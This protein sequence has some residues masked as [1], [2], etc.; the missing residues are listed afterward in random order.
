[1]SEINANP[2]K[3][4]KP[5]GGTLKKSIKPFE[6]TLYVIGFVIGSGIFLKPSSVLKNT[7]STAGSLMAWIVGGVIAITAALTIGEIAAYIPKTGGMHTYLT[8]LYGDKFGF[9]YGWTESVIACTG[10]SAALAI[11]FATFATFFLPMND[12][13]LK[14]FAILMIVLIAAAQIISTRFGVWLQTVSTIGKLVP[15]I[16]LVAFG[17]IHGTVNNLS[18]ASA[19]LVK[20]SGFGTALLGVLWAYDGWLAVCTLGGEI[21]HSEKSLPFAIISGVSFVMVVYILFNMAIFHVLPVSTVATS[22]K[23]G[24][25]ASI[26]LFG[27]GGTIFITVGMLLAVFGALNA[28]MSVGTR[29]FFSIG[30]KDQIPGSKI[31]SAVNPKSETPINA[32]LIHSII[33]II[34]IA[35]GSF[36]SITNLVIFTI[37]I[38]YTMGIASIFVLRKRIPHNPK[39]YKVPLYPL[40]PILGMVGGIYMLLSTV[41]KTPD[42]AMLGICLCLIGLPFYYLHKKKTETN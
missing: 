17:L 8:E 33:A 24:V 16:A 37:W 39:L 4:V 25:D 41:I 7:G 22:A 6:A 34:F 15:I 5:I 14:A 19:G 38:F 27:D 23:V 20:G 3:N 13:Q 26:K 29:Y 1:M 10:S 31:L 21:E 12:W 36:N 9:L 35:T 2:N 32:I 28:Q 30:A 40:T 18:F 42:K 11:A